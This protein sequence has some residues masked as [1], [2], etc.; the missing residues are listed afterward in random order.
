M[1]VFGHTSE[2][3]EPLSIVKMPDATGYQFPR[4]LLEHVSVSDRPAGMGTDL[5]ECNLY[6]FL[7]GGRFVSRPGYGLIEP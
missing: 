3:F 2:G 1:G 5:I 6:S 7:D 4:R